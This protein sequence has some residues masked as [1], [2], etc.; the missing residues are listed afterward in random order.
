MKHQDEVIATGTFIPSVISSETGWQEATVNVVYVDYPKIAT[1]VC[2]QFWSTSKTSFSNS[3]F[4]RNKSISFPI[5]GDWN[6]HI[7]SM[8]YV[9]DISLIYDK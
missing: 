9:D 1:S 5:M 2:V 3:D 4:D 7:G 8:F 6:V